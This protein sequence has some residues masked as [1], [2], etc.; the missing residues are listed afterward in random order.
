MNLDG[1]VEKIQYTNEQEKRMAENTLSLVNESYGEMRSI[2]HRMMPSAL[3][4]SGLDTALRE[5]VAK[6]DPDKLR[7]DLDTSGLDDPIGEHIE[8]TIYRVIQEC[9]ANV[10]KHS[11]ASRLD[12]QVVRDEEG[13][14]VTLEDNGKGFDVKMLDTSAGMGMRNIVSRV[15]Y[16]H[17]TINVDSDQRRGTL[18]AI[19][20]PP[21]PETV[22]G[23]S[24][25]QSEQT[26]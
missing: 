12:I 10:V 8:T 11:S 7:I 5:F 25:Q 9:V 16:L 22:T 23:Y 18:I 3:I 17:G 13:L 2:S 6:I 1:L 26:A 21:Q 19:H 4:N 20:I 15:H 14:S 24:R